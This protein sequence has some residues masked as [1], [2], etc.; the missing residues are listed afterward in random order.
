MQYVCVFF[1][2][3]SIL[4]ASRNEKTHFVFS[5]SANLDGNSIQTKLENQQGFWIAQPWSAKAVSRDSVN[6]KT[7]LAESI[8]YTVSLRSLKYVTIINASLLNASYLLNAP[9]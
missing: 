2:A 3:C 4:I 6:T 9:S 8:L 5:F 7:F 1:P